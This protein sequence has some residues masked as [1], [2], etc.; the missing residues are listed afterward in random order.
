[1]H[2]MRRAGLRH[3]PLVTDAFPEVSNVDEVYPL[4]SFLEPCPSSVLLRVA[5]L[6]QELCLL[7]EQHPPFLSFGDVSSKTLS[8]L[9][10]LVC[11]RGRFPR[12]SWM[13]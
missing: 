12:V 1:M 6:A 11:R 7:L 3:L 8:S 9:L 10:R 2:V 13:Y 5:F 4:V